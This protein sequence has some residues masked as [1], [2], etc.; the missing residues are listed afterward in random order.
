MMLPSKDA[1][2]SARAHPHRTHETLWLSQKKACQLRSRVLGSSGTCVEWSLF[3][4]LMILFLHVPY[5]PRQLPSQISMLTMNMF[6]QVENQA[7]GVTEK[8]AID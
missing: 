7:S 2:E 1:R 6:H 3:H 8:S 5:L 4:S